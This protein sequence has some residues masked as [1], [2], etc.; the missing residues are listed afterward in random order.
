MNVFIY[1]YMLLSCTASVEGI[2]IFAAS[3]LRDVLPKINDALEEQMGVEVIEQYAGSQTLATQIQHGATV[4][5]MI[6]ANPKYINIL[7]EKGFVLSKKA[8]VKN[9]L[10]V[11]TPS[12]NPASMSTYVDLTKATSVVLGK[13]SSP[14]GMYT[15]YFLQ[16]KGWELATMTIIPQIQA[17]L[18]LLVSEHPRQGISKQLMIKIGSL[19]ILLL[20]KLI[21]L[22]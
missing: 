22:T 11:I 6:S 4:D 3:S 21:K 20:E 14:I 15:N 7:E 18:A 13:S 1:W 16:K 19:L 8:I 2:N 12:N 5:F 9:T 10:V 17:R